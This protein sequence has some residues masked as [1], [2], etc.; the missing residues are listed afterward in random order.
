MSTFIVLERIDVQKAN[1]IAGFTWG[2]PAITHFLGFSHNLS[3]KL[4]GEYQ[5]KLTGCG[6]VCH[7]HQVHVC[8]HKAGADYKFI[9]GKNSVTTKKQASELNS[10]GKNPPIIEEGKMH[11]NASLIIECKG[12]I[13]G[14]ETGFE[15]FKRYI[16]LLCCQQKLAGGSINAIQSISIHSA[17]TEDEHKKLLRRIKRLLLPGFVLMDRSDMLSAHFEKL[18]TENNDVELVDA[19][20]DFSALKY[21]A[22][23]LLNKDEIKPTEKTKAVW[24]LLPKPYNG[25]LVP[26]KTGYRA[27]SNIYPPSV[28]KNVR[29][30]EV[31]V[32]FVESIHSI[33]EWMGIHKLTD[34]EDCLWNYHFHNDLYLCRQQ[35]EAESTEESQPPT[36]DIESFLSTL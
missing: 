24:E 13:A 2:F 18:K 28:V 9:Q 8:R 36:N 7:Q 15:Q 11:F 26:I 23:P 10:K 31:P 1:C 29:D 25:W 27:I 17:G 19:W 33:G 34:I 32:C 4:Q 12:L 35:K 21:K 30:N 16:E 20:L 3:R 5:I 6:V 14:G 22:T